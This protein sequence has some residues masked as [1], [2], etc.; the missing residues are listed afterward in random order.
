[1]AALRNSVRRWGAALIPGPRQLRVWRRRPVEVLYPQNEEAA[2][3]G[4]AGEDRSRPV[5]RNPDPAP[6]D[7]P[8]PPFGPSSLDGLSYEKAFPG[9]KRLA[10]VVILAKSKKFRE[11]HGKILVEGR[12]LITDALG[13]G[14]LLQTLFFSSVESL[15]ELPLEKLKHVKLIKVKFEE[16]KM[17]SDLV[18]PQGAIGIFVRPDRSKM[19]YPAVQQEHT[20]PLFLIGDNIRDPGNLGT[21]LRSAAAAGCSKVLLTKGCVDVWEPKVLRAGM[22]AHFRIPVISNLEWGVIPNYLSGSTQVH[23]ADSSQGGADRYVPPPDLGAVGNRSWG[24]TEYQESDSEDEESVFPLS[25]PKVGARC[26]SQ[27]WA[28]E[29]TAIVIG[30]ETYGLSLEALSLAEQTGGQR[31]YIPM[32]PGMDSLNSAMAASVLLFEGR[33]QLLAQVTA[34]K[35]DHGPS[36]GVV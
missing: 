6:R 9:D 17:W 18:T 11:Q 4:R 36:S 10:K 29:V 24:Q 16:I 30:G 25:L 34:T 12:R 14:A 8:R 26:Y 13:A 1:M 27:H 3:A 33:R 32:V 22:G 19:K 35:Q 15:R 7:Q 2:A 5:T 31:L 28:R 23:V 20:I 21:I